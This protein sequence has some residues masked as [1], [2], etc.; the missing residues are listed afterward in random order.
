M[1]R[2]FAAIITLSAFTAGTFAQETNPSSTFRKSK[3]KFN[4]EVSVIGWVQGETGRRTPASVTAEEP[5]FR[6]KEAELSLQSNVDAYGRAELFIGF[7]GEGNVELEE[8]YLNWTSL[9]YNLALKVGKFRNNFGKFNR[10]HVPETDFADRPLVAEHFFGGEGL[11]GP[12]VSLSWQI[13]NPWFFTELTS[14]IVNNP[15]AAEV[16]AF[17]TARKRDL[18]YV[19]RLSTYHDLTEALNV[20]MGGSYAYGAAGQEFNTVSLSSRTL[21]SEIGGV[22]LTFRWK[23]PRKAI[24]RSA[25][26]QTEALWSKRDAANSSHVGSWGMF[27]HLQYQFARRWRVGIRYDYTQLPTDGIMHEAGGL[28]YL[29]F[30]PSEF[31]LISL[32]GRRARRFDG[33]KE[34][35]GWLK[36]TFNIGPHGSHPF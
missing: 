17:D 31:S 32:Q 35:L 20:T 25:F 36:M 27:S 11:S 29:T 8:G 1:R 6:F 34:T 9:P 30:T 12:G 14:E 7:D 19:N 28:A 24:Y 10:T 21:K 13:P 3:N 15:E 26:W 18:L 5:V 33:D 23:N 2:I 16:P 4:P 22:D